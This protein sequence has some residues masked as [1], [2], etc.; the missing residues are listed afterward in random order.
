[1]VRLP[2]MLANQSPR[3]IS[4]HRASNPGGGGNSNASRSSRGDKTQID[5]GRGAATA[6]FENAGEI[7]GFSNPSIT[8]ES[9]A[10]D[11][12]VNLGRDLFPVPGIRR[13]DAAALWRGA[14]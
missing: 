10:R 8:A 9:G 5:E 4:L 11:G 6:G 12:H 7:R 3:A 13:P 2:V 1:M 14:S